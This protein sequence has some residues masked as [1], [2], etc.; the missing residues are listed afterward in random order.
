VKKKPEHNVIGRI[1][2]CIF[3]SKAFFKKRV[4][5]V[6]ISMFNFQVRAAHEDDFASPVP[7]TL[8]GKRKGSIHRNGNFGYEDS[9]GRDQRVCGLSGVLVAIRTTSTV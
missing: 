3:V 4:E 9:P 8:A 6:Q 7:I 2:G 1:F 5:I